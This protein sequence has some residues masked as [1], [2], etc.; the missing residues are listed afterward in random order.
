MNKEELMLCEMI[1]ASECGVTVVRTTLRVYGKDGHRQRASFGKSFEFNMSDG[2]VHI[3][4]L[5]KDRT[6]TNSFVE[7]VITVD[8]FKRC[9]NELITQLSD[10]IFEA[11]NVGKIIIKDIEEGYDG[12]FKTIKS[13][14]EEVI[15]FI[16]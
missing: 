16:K 14:I 8:S 2:D 9:I 15:A 12:H 10:G 11:C 5:C 4:C 7:L 3:E 1:T 6:F 13:E